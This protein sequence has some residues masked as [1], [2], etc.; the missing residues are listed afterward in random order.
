MAL[1]VLAACASATN[2]RLD[3]SPAYY[4]QSIRGHLAVWQSAQ[5]V[6]RLI[7]DSATPEVLRERLRLA[8]S[9][10]RFAS[11]TLL[12]PD[13]G[14]YT[15]YS[16]LGRP[17]VV[18]NVQATPELSL[19]PRRW[20]FPVAGCVAY[21]G[22]FSREAAEAEAAALRAE[23]LDV[24]VSGVAAYS[25]LGWFDDPLL[26]SFIRYAEP[27]LARLIFHE[28]AHQLIYVPDDT[29]FNESFAT[30]LEE[31]G[32]LKW[33]GARGDGRALIDRWE[34]QR[35]RR[36]EFIELLM[37][38][39]DSLQALYAQDLPV[40]YKRQAKRDILQALR[41]R[42]RL[43]RERWGG[44]GAYDAWFAQP[45]GNAHLAAIGLYHDHVPAFRALYRLETESLPAFYR[46]VRELAALPAEA[47]AQRLAA[48]AALGR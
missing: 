4:W 44:D 34:Q 41:E 43:L 10:R 16:E 28:L 48:L 1:P 22:Y 5:P 37:S 47:R 9:I 42:Y 12:L 13:N 31:I 40:E 38:V 3:L 33:L 46:A 32:V 18:W 25:T 19:E 2:A 7:A 29:R 17:Y 39:R 30:A 26:S 27:D 35:A 15:R 11:D 8:Q 21:R 45:L 24:Q 6:D 20:C 23:G 36:T 14:S